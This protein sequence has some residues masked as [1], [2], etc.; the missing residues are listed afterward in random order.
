MMRSRFKVELDGDD[1]VVLID[2]DRG[3]SITND[4]EMVVR[5]IAEV[6][7]LT[8]RRIVYRDT[9]GKWDGIAVEGGRFAHFVMLQLDSREDAVYQA[10]NRG[11]W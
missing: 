11:R 4:A 5:E 1:V 8:A 9:M 10:R 3:R 7:D 6:L 2:Q